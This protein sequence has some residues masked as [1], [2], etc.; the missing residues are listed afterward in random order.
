MEGLIEIE[1]PNRIVKKVKKPT[2]KVEDDGPKEGPTPNRA[3]SS[4]VKPELS[5]REREELEKQRARAHYQKLHAEGM[6]IYP[7]SISANH[8][9]INVTLT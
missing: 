6:L 4:S 9:S 2:A 5:R 1:N 8:N 7:A 3:S